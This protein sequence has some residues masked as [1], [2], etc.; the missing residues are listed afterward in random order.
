MARL[1]I[2]DPT[3]GEI[4]PIGEVLNVTIDHGV[5]NRVDRGSGVPVF[6]FSRAPEVRITMTEGDALRFWAWLL[7]DVARTCPTLI[8]SAV[9]RAWLET[10]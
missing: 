10:S 5:D 8:Q 7:V 6:V 4:T 9:L 1:F 3:S 2:G